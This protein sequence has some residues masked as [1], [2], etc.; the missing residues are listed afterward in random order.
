MT[1]HAGD[2]PKPWLDQ[3][4]R[5]RVRWG[6][7][8]VVG[9]VGLLLVGILSLALVAALPG[10]SI[11]LE[12]IGFA[13]AGLSIALLLVGFIL[14]DARRAW[15]RACGGV[16]LALC[17]GGV[18]LFVGWF[19]ELW[20]STLG[21]PNVFAIGQYLVGLVLLGAGAAGGV[22]GSILDAFRERPDPGGAAEEPVGLDEVS[23]DGYTWGGVSADRPGTTLAFSEDARSF[24]VEGSNGYL[25]R[26]EEGRDVAYAVD[27]LL[28][29]QGRV[30]NARS[31][32]G[33][34]RQ[35]SVLGIVRMWERIELEAVEDAW[36][37]RFW[38][39]WGG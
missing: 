16:G 9:S 19:P 7:T 28:A 27:A 4:K 6:L 3:G 25:V 38:P 35:S 29:L 17:M 18:I 20:G 34:E 13:F 26:V 32:G 11:T 1:A 15:V 24:Q 14:F 31:E 12:T 2:V 10:G 23:V 37:R 8:T 30:V 33:V 22:L 36:W 21:V 39:P 5:Q